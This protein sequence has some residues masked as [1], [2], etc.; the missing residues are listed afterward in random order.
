MLGGTVVHSGRIRYWGV[1]SFEPAPWRPPDLDRPAVPLPGP[2]HAL[3]SPYRAIRYGMPN[4]LRVVAPHVPW[5]WACGGVSPGVERRD[6]IDAARVAFDDISRVGG[7]TQGAFQGRVRRSEGRLSGPGPCR[8]AERVE[9]AEAA[10]GKNQIVGCR[11]GGDQLAEDLRVRGG[12]ACD[13]GRLQALEEKARRGRRVVGLGELGE[14]KK[15][16]GDAAEVTG[17]PEDRQDR[18]RAGAARCPGAA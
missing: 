7:R 10:G 18:V 17:L 3:R 4:G 2:P 15:G 8:V 13:G 12:A 9:S 5:P 14:L 16:P 1:T 6:E 11:S